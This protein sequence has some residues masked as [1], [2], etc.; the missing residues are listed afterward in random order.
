ML[1]VKQII[2]A[3]NKID[4]V[5]YSEA[6]YNKVK[7]ELEKFLKGIGYKVDEVPF[8]PVSALEGENIIKSSAKMP[9]FKG[10]PILTT[11]DHLKEPEKPTSLPLRLPVQDVYSITGIGTVPV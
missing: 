4:A 2:V 9:W 3:I 6:E 7:S 10:H 11:L 8:V 5:N 1:G